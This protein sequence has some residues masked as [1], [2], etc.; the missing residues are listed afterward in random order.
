MRI[1]PAEL[2]KAEIVKAI[3]KVSYRADEMLLQKI[4]SHQADNEHE[5]SRE[6]LDMI[7]KNNEIAA[8]DRIPLC[9]DTGTTVAF[10]ELGDE[11]IV[12][13]DTLQDILDQAVAE[14]HS[15]YFLRASMLSD[16]VF[17]RKNTE[18]NTPG[19]LHLRQVKGDGLRIILAQKGGGAE[20]MSFL[21][22]M[23]PSASSAQIADFVVSGVISSGSKACPP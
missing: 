8:G 22:M 14:A 13:G 23:D 20:N 4:R 11:V 21:R 10:V 1:I 9:Q 6:I 18:D 3:G 7:L 5:A 16:P 19:I 15:A 17:K 12:Q 2:I